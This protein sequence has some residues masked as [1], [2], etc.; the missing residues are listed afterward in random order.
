MIDEPLYN[1]EEG[2]VTSIRKIGTKFEV[3]VNSGKRTAVYHSLDLVNVAA[4][5]KVVIGDLI[6]YQNAAALS[7]SSATSACS[8]YRWINFNGNGTHEYQNDIMKDADDVEVYFE[9]LLK[10]PDLAEDSY[11]FDPDL[12]KITTIEIMPPIWRIRI[13]V[14]KVCV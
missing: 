12:G 1:Q 9:G 13:K 3:T 10:T 8:T 14:K 2:T 6:G 5:S 4:G 7:S 11:T